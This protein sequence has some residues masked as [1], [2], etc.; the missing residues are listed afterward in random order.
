MV[1]GREPPRLLDYTAGI[2]QVEAVDVALEQH[3]EFIAL[4][5]ERLLDALQRMKLT[6]DNHHRFVE[7]NVGDWV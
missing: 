5:R 3:D 7:F 6:Y 4:A 1:Y 2:S